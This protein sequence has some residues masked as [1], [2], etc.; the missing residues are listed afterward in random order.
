MKQMLFGAALVLAGTAGAANADPAA[1]GCYH[2]ICLGAY[3]SGKTIYFDLNNN[4]TG[5]APQFLLRDL[6]ASHARTRSIAQ[7]STLPDRF[8]KVRFGQ[9]ETTS[10]KRGR[11]SS[12]AYTEV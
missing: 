5:L 1:I 6:S 11:N 8:G 9:V 3:S 10:G 7:L 4:S 12:E 2:R